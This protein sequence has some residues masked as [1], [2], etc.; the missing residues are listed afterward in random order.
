MNKGFKKYGKSRWRSVRLYRPAALRA[1]L[2]RAMAHSV[3]MM[4]LAQLSAIRSVT[5]VT[6]MQR[7][8]KSLAI[9]K[10]AG[11]SVNAVLKALN[12]DNQIQH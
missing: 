1:H 2:R 6:P 5:A 10:V 4:A 11:Q 12:Y 3:G 7:A 9:A 8:A